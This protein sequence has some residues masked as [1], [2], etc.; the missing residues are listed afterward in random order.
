MRMMG[1]YRPHHGPRHGGG[2]RTACS[3][4]KKGGLALGE[5]QDHVLSQDDGSRE[6]AAMLNASGRVQSFWKL[7]SGGRW[8]KR[9]EEKEEEEEDWKLGV[10]RRKF[11]T[12]RACEEDGVLGG[13]AKH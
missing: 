3:S 6:S 8:R 1:Q 7:T 5:E 2:G 4:R 10:Q 9:E 11:G 13:L 12:E